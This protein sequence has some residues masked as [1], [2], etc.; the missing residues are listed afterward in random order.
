M[1]TFQ[2]TPLQF[3]NWIWTLEELADGGADGS[4]ALLVFLF[5]LAVYFLNVIIA[6][7]EVENVRESAPARV[8]ADDALQHPEPAKLAASPWDK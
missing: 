3:S 1:T 7:R 2:Y 5:G 6:A 8:R 4:V